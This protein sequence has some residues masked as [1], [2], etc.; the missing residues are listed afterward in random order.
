MPKTI[1]NSFDK[2]LTFVN[3]YHAY[4]RI[5][6]NKR[7]KKDI[8]NYYI[9]LETN[10]INLLNELKSNTYTP[11]KYSEFIIYEPKRRIIKSLPLKDRIVHQWYIEEF[12]KPYIIKR[13]IPD[14]YACIE[15]RG[16]HKALEKLEY[17]MR[18]M[19][20][21]NSNYYILKCDIKNYFYSINKNILYNI[22]TKYITDKKLLNLTKIIIYSN[23]NNKL[24]I[25]IGN[26]TS[27]Y[28]ANIYL[29][30]LDRYVKEELKIKY[31]IRY[32]DDFVIL[33]DSREIAKDVI[34][35]IKIF[36]H[37][38][39]ELELNKKSN[40]FPNR[41]GID[42]CGYRIFNTHRLVRKRSKVKMVRKINKWNK[43][44]DNHQNLD[45]IK[46]NRSIN[47]WLSQ[48]KHA[49]SY[50]LKNKVLNRIKFNYK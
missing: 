18:I 40:Y 47:S 43:L 34:N 13:F 4:F 50:K 42:F 30:E 27:Q 29:H 17:Y 2:K 8:L 6:K 23:D 5:C 20:R 15:G 48:I 16:V 7:N 22:M 9:D 37:N 41:L 49:N 39:L 3:L 36:L 21:N 31:Y 33:L 44:Y 45:L 1:K 24:G 38:K 35:K 26:Y 32:M 19:N 10:L 25:P 11:G 12:I 14:T 28:Y 46:I